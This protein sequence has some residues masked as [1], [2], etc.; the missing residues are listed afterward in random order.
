[1]STPPVPPLSLLRSPFTRLRRISAIDSYVY[2]FALQ[3][4]SLP[5][6]TEEETAIMAQIMLAQLPPRSRAD[7]A[8]G[9]LSGLATIIDNSVILPGPA[10]AHTPR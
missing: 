5:F 9:R 3:E 10:L 4:K 1:M 6:K 7:L 8:L 2:G